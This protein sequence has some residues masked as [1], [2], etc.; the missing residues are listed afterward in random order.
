M[1]DQAGPIKSI[2][3]I[4]GGTAGWMTAASLVHALGRQGVSITLVES[5]A[6]GT[7]GVGE[8]TVPAIRRYFQS[9][10]MDVLDVMKATN[11]TFKLAIAFDDWLH[12]GHR[13]LHPF[14]RYGVAAGPIGFHHLWT[15]MRQA[16]D[17]SPLGD[18][19]LGDALAR[20]G[21]FAL[22][23]TATHDAAQPDFMVYDWA[24]HFDA[25]L[26]AQHLRRFAEAR[27]VRRIDAK[28]TEVAL[29]SET[30]F[31]DSVVLDTGVEVAA[32]LFV[33]CSGFRSILSQQTLGVK[34][35]D[36][37][38]WLPCDRAVALPCAHADGGDLT[39]FT[40]SRAEEAGWTWRIPLQHRVG[41]G[42]V[43]S[44]ALL[45]DH[46]A[47][48]H[49]RRGLEGEAL[50]SANFVRFRPGH[51]ERFWERNCVAIG[52]AAGF[53]EPLES[54]SITLIQAGIDKL[55][56]FFP[57]ADCAPELQAEYNRISTLEFERI[58]DFII[59]HYWANR[60][61]DQPLWKH[62]REEPLPDTLAHKIALFRA[63]GKLAQYDWD[64]FHEPSWLCV[65]T[66]MGV[67]PRAYDPQADAIG[68]PSIETLAANIRRDVRRMASDAPRHADFIA[69]YCKAP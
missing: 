23:P 10:D 47:E 39:P 41:N 46:D 4:G 6:I 42:Y 14:G 68:L 3:I 43:Y 22:P 7:V 19:S 30:G 21:R 48:A 16:G 18:Y 54:T 28:V 56:E 5:S 32:D 61:G 31:I 58:R 9:L 15:R 65:M 63:A 50:A 29:N 52:L 36:W 27:G 44:S 59:L 57:R 2:A 8:A 35:R 13:F 62:C 12:E 1:S 34:F 25:S 24:L 49:L 45:S 38:R 26:F 51:V 53:L 60:R 11:G 69:R 67:L 33:D 66:G 40:R 64:S 20:E 17:Q 55:L 37:S